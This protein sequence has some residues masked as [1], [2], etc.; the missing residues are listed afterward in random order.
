M[1]DLWSFFALFFSLQIVSCVAYFFHSV[2]F[3]EF[4]ALFMLGIVFCAAGLFLSLCLIYRVFVPF[5][6]LGIVSC[7]C[8]NISFILFDLLSF[9]AFF[10]LGTVSCVAS[11]FFFFYGIFAS[12]FRLGI[13]SCVSRVVHSPFSPV[14]VVLVQS[15]HQYCFTFVRFPSLC[16]FSFRALSLPF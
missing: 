5:F 16:F 13:V 9:P 1:F 10:M 3:T 6:M 14:F 15:L 2:S 7:V 8:L 4:F 12:F 11:L